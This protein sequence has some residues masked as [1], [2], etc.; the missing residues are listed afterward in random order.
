MIRSLSPGWMLFF[1]P[2]LR[3]TNGGYSAYFR[4]L[5]GTEE[6]AVTSSG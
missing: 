6:Y 1:S 5:P 4:T 2:S 3:C